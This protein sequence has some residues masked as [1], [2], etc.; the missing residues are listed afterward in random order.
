MKTY[1]DRQFAESTLQAAD[2]MG[3]MCEAMEYTG[4][5]T[6][7]NM[8]RNPETARMVNRARAI[9]SKARYQ[10]LNTGASRIMGGIEPTEPERASIKAVWDTLPGYTCFID[11]LAITARW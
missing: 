2:N 7:G 11:A 4:H 3:G 6:L 9:S 5:K 8:A 10:E 1:A